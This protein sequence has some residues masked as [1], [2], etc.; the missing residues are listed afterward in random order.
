MIRFFELMTSYLRP[1]QL[2]A[3]KMSQV[4]LVVEAIER[5]KKMYEREAG[6]AIM[7]N[8]LVKGILCLESKVFLLKKIPIFL[9]KGD[10]REKSVEAITELLLYD[11]PIQKAKTIMGEEGL[12]SIICQIS[13]RDSPLLKFAE[14]TVNAMD[15]VRD[16]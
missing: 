6:I 15:V 4:I 1:K 9:R 7:T 13:D 2:S 14:E 16:E 10:G 3:F 5:T 12:F 11:L 8:L